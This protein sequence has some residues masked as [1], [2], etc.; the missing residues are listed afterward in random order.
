MSSQR[1]RKS[2][3]SVKP[4]PKT[5]K[6]VK[7][8]A[9]RVSAVSLEESKI[10]AFRPPKVH[11][12]KLFGVPTTQ[13]QANE[14]Y[15]FAKDNGYVCVS[16][17]ITK[18][19]NERLMSLLWDWAEGASSGL[20]RG[21]PSTW[22]NKNWLEMFSAGM[23]KYQGIGQSEALWTAR[24]NE[25]IYRVFQALYNTDGP[26]MTSFDGAS[27]FRG[28]QPPKAK[29]WPHFDQDTKK[30]PQVPRPSSAA[31]IS[32]RS[33]TFSF[34]SRTLSART[35]ICVHRTFSNDTHIM[36][37]CVHRTLGKVYCN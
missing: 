20:R 7:K 12:P 35:Y 23:F 11:H 34:L 15:R 27:I 21:D 8:A 33:F 14:L 9:K 1:K 2:L 5:K 17:V 29:P 25:K 22:V 28:C 24:C 36:Y 32:F 16:N 30:R 37:I 26:L 13:E 3:S 6:S 10:F 18:E 19:Q 4:L 31:V